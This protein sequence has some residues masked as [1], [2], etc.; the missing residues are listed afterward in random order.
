MAANQQYLETPTAHNT[1][2]PGVGNLWP[3][4]GVPAEPRFDTFDCQITVNGHVLVKASISVSIPSP[5][6]VRIDHLSTAEGSPLHQNDLVERFCQQRHTTLAQIPYLIITNVIEPRTQAAYDQVYNSVAQDVGQAVTFRA[7]DPQ[8]ATL[9]NTP[10]G[11]TV[12]F[13]IP[14]GANGLTL[15]SLNG[16]NMAFWVTAEYTPPPA[17]APHGFP[18]APN[19]GPAPAPRRST[20]TCCVIM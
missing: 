13:G 8:Y 4:L 7:T 17:P 10:I 5:D 9:L 15:M 18:P 6:I 1:R 12:R 19:P 11:N 14:Q 16:R 2:I 3:A 20:R